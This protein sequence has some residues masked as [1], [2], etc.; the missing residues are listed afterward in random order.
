MTQRIRFLGFSF[1][2]TSTGKVVQRLLPENVNNERRK[3]KALVRRSKNGLMT[4][5]DVNACYEGS[6]P[7]ARRV[8]NHDEI[9]KMDA[10]YKSL[11]EVSDNVQVQKC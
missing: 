3:L 9:L 6:K 1:E 4:R 7:H 5:Q 8:H 11:W 10:Y 2:L